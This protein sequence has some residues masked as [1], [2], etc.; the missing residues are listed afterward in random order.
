METSKSRELTRNKERTPAPTRRA[1]TERETLAPPVD[2]FEN[3]DEVLLI[4]DLPGVLPNEVQIRYERGELVLEARRTVG[5]GNG[6]AITGDMGGVDYV[7]SFRVSSAIDPDKIEADLRQGV[8][9]LH[10]PKRE[11]LKPR[12]IPIKAG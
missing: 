10:L 2:I 1:M 5:L 9:R 4:A 8:L 7:R 3:D 11:T 12:Q 6:A